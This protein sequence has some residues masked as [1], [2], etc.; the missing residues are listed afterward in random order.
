M[1]K[2]K[3]ISIKDVMRKVE[4]KTGKKLKLE[5]HFTGKK[6]TVKAVER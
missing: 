3:K 1:S 2:K 5:T 4:R 6:W